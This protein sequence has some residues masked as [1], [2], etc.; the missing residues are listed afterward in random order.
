MIIRTQP[1][2]RE[3]VRNSLVAQGREV[4]GEFPALDAIIAEVRC[5]DL[6]VIAGFTQT[7]SVSANAKVHG[8]QLWDLTQEPV[9]PIADDTT[10][11]EQPVEV[12][13]ALDGL[14]ADADDPI[15]TVEDGTAWRQIQLDPGAYVLQATSATTAGPGV[16]TAS[17]FFLDGEPVGDFG[18]Y[19]H[20]PVATDGTTHSHATVIVVEGEPRTLVQ[21]VLEPLGYRVLSATDGIEAPGPRASSR[22]SAGRVGRTCSMAA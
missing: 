19:A 21:R 18:G 7:A 3:A 6:T 16:A 15:P 2:A 13:E 5:A 22:E 12:L 14:A 8:H 10:V 9:A 17:R 20:T 1:G 4:K 11:V